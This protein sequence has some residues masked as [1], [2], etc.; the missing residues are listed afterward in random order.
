MKTTKN[1][2][3]SE[4]FIYQNATELFSLKTDSTR[5][6]DDFIK[7]VVDFKPLHFMKKEDIIFELEKMEQN[8]DE[9]L[10]E[11]KILETELVN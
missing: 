11:F 6:K 4:K 3:E 8:S 7:F 9:L 5:A 1:L 2:S 10:K